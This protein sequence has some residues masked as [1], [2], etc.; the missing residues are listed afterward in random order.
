MQLTSMIG[1]FDS[2]TNTEGLC[3]T[4]VQ[5]WFEKL[6]LALASYLGGR[7]EHVEFDRVFSMVYHLLYSHAQVYVKTQ[8]C[9][10]WTELRV[11]LTKRFGLTDQ[12]VKS[13]LWACRQKGKKSI[14]A[15]FD[16]INAL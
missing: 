8:R 2:S 1:K 15:Y 11:V 10:A 9:T 16:R 6:N 4:G 14:I 7:P 13:A 12:H 5:A 3:S